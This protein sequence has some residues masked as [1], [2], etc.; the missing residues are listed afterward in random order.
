MTKIYINRRKHELNVAIR[1]HCDRDVCIAVSTITNTLAQ[2]TEDFRDRN[3][4]FRTDVLKVKSGNTQISV[5]CKDGRVFRRY[6]QGADALLL[7]YELYED[8]FPKE[9]SVQTVDA[10]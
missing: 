6:M 8:N 7:G 1:G 2:Y 3:S 9:I 10:I 5:G 4:G